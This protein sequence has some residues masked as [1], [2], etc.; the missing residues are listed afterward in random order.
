MSGQSLSKEL[1]AQSRSPPP[2]YS[3][4]AASHSGLGEQIYGQGHR[5]ELG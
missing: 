1:P 2:I 3:Q 5:W 4:A